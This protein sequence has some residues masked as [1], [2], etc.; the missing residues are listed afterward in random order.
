MSRKRCNGGGIVLDRAIKS[1]PAAVLAMGLCAL[2]L[3]SASSLMQVQLPADEHLQPLLSDEYL[4][5]FPLMNLVANNC[6]DVAL[7]PGDAQILAAVGQ[8]IVELMQVSAHTQQEVYLNAA[9]TEMALPDSCANY[10]PGILPVVTQLRAL[11]AQATP[12]P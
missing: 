3:A 2:P 4:F 11:G 8:R 6:A 10:A 12:L 9:L 5:I 7:A 1:L